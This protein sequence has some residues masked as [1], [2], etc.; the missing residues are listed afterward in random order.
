MKRINLG[1]RSWFN[2]DASTI[3]TESYRWD[4]QNYISLAT[5]SQ[6]EHATLYRTA[7]GT[8]VLKRW[9]DWPGSKEN[10]SIVS[11]Y[12]AY[13]WLFCNNHSKAVEEYFSDRLES[14]EV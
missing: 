12:E 11:D 1:N 13:A 9:S 6:W 14:N 5:E 8:W 10:Y 4:G 7:K 2:P 3:F